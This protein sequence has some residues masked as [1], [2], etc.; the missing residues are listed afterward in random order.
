MPDPAAFSRSASIPFFVVFTT[1]PRSSVLCREIAADATITVSL[2]RQVHVYWSSP[3]S[4]SPTSSSSGSG[5][6]SDVPSPR[7][8]LL[9]RVVKSAPSVTSGSNPFSYSGRGRY[10]VKDKPLPPIPAGKQGI[11]DSR[12]LQT[13]VSIGFP[14]R[15]RN[16]MQPHERHPTLDAHSAL[17]DGL[18]KGMLQLNKNMLPTVDWAGLSVKV[19]EIHG[20]RDLVS[21][22]VAVLRGSICSIRAG[23]ATGPC[24]CADLLTLAPATLDPRV[25]PASP[26]TVMYPALA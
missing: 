9:H 17:P 7:R 1:R 19:C 26:S 3:S 21:T 25:Y 5:D 18:Y 24:S 20:C 23:R 8:R 16:R 12:T 13:D 4:H 14:K 2:I 11:S 6:E 15:P 10:A 22:L